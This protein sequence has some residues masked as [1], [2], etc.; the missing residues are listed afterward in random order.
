[1]AV[2][3]GCKSHALLYGRDCFPLAPVATITGGKEHDECESERNKALLEQVPESPS[4]Y[5]SSVF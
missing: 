3:K 4:I 5:S 1:M 2:C